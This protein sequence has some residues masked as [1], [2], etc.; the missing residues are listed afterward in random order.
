MRLLF[1][2]PQIRDVDETQD[3][4]PATVQLNVAF[5]KGLHG[6]GQVAQAPFNFG[7]GSNDSSEKL[8]NPFR[9]F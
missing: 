5:S 4:V 2:Y 7:P 9:L 6:P 3:L 8:Y 1:L